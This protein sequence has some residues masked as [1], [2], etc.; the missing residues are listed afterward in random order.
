LSSPRDPITRERRSH[1]TSLI[2]AI[3]DL[4]DGKTATNNLPKG[5]ERIERATIEAVRLKLVDNVDGELLSEIASAEGYTVD[6]GSFAPRVTKEGEIIAR[7]GSKSD[8][9]GSRDLYLYLFPPETE[10]ISVY[11]KVV[12]EREEILDPSS[13]MVDLERLISFDLRVITLASKYLKKRYGQ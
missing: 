9:G 1:P 7:I 5:I 11:R 3:S 10:R 6:K 4:Y 2:Q 12:G 13:G 8:A